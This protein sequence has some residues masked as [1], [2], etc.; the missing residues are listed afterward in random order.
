MPTSNR[1]EPATSRY[2]LTG[3]PGAGK[4]AVLRLLEA[5]GHLVVEE[6]ATDVIAL[7]QALGQDEPWASPSFIDKI[8]TLQRQRQTRLAA[9]PTV[10]V[11][12]DRSPVCTLALA[13]YLGFP[14][15]A[16]LAA[17]LARIAAHRV[18]HPAVFFLRNQGTI[19]PTPARRISYEDSLAF[20]KVHED[21]YRELGFQLIE[22]PPGPL[23]HRAALIE[24][25]AGRPVSPAP[26]R[27]S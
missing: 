13:R 25:L 26:P 12:F 17:E 11:F 9:G 2:V 18:Y 19:R 5:R 8:V 23:A 6:A 21:T 16:G 10:P 22:I 20:E 24:R 4:T 7:E 15:G 14:V 1:T 3:T 27:P